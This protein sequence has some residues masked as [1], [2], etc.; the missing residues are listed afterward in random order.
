MACM[1]DTHSHI[2]APSQT[3][4]FADDCIMYATVDTME[5]RI[6][7][8]LKMPFKQHWQHGERT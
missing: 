1:N 5:Y 7:L 4:L 8:K 3:G 6:K 2:K